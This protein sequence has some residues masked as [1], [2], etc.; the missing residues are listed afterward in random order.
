MCISQTSIALRS[1]CLP[2]FTLNMMCLHP[3]EPAN[4]VQD[5][6]AFAVIMYAKSDVPGPTPNY[7]PASASPPEARPCWAVVEV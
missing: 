5:A 2:Y 7:K 3:P 1:P 6:P 4:T